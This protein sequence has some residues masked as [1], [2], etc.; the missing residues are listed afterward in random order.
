MLK[1]GIVIFACFCIATVIT[2]TV[3]LGLLWS[4]GQLNS[5]TFREIEVILTGEEFMGVGD[6]DQEQDG[7]QTS[8]GDID[9]QRVMAILDFEEREGLAKQLFEDVMNIRA[10]V[11]Q[12]QEDLRKDRAVFEA[13]LQKV[14]EKITA[15]STELA[16]GVL[17]QSKPKDAVDRLM[18][19]KLEE[20]VILMR[21]M[22][23]ENIA[24]ILKEFKAGQNQE[25]VK[26]ARHIYESLYRGE[27]ARSVVDQQLNQPQPA[28]Q[29]PA[30]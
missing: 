25:R 30:G 1:T 6:D 13:E 2:E 18:D 24:K 14:N 16:R 22:P 28:A 17:L 5:R 7:Q 29:G 19:L 27:P 8:M 4:R 15:E 20:D 3:G 11:T 12:Q 10:E 26:R 23:E 21:G 9:N